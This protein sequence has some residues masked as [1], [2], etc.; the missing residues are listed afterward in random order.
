MMNLLAATGANQQVL[1][2][3][4]IEYRGILPILI[5]SVGAIVLLLF[6]SLIRPRFDARA[7]AFITVVLGLV[8][9]VASAL[10]WNDVDKSGAKPVFADALAL[11]HYAVFFN[12]IIVSA[13]ILSALIASDWLS[14]RK[15]H[16]P[17]FFVLMTIAAAGAMVMAA[18][19]DLIVIFL[20]LEILSIALYVLVAMD[21][22]S[23][24]SREGALKYF[25]LGGF[26][27]AIFLYGIALT[28]GATGSTNLTT[29]AEFFSSNTLLEQGLM[30]AGMALLAV[31]FAFKI[32]AVPFHQWTPDVYQGAPTPVTA[33]MAAA[34]KAGAFA[35]L[36]RVFASSFYTMKLDWQ[37]MFLW[38]AIA[39]LLVGSIAACVR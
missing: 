7:C 1:N 18:A 14:E 36:L 9:L 22:G 30:L 2:L 20:G 32:A 39:T 6:S 8:A 21:R 4:Q 19:N 17:E 23:E 24:G 35:A 13:L 26:S 3:P 10:Q 25:I 29:I 38:L 31:G 5:L 15:Q 12:V 34:A 16:G 37:P 33:F 27:S 11:D 28:Y